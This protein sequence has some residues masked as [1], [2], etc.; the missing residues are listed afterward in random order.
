M[1]KHL[2]AI[3]ASVSALCLAA[4]FCTS[5][6]ASAALGF[7]PKTVMTKSSDMWNS[8]RNTTIHLDYCTSKDD[9]QDYLYTPGRDIRA[10]SVSSAPGHGVAIN[11][12]DVLGAY[13]GSYDFWQASQ[14]G[15]YNVEKAYDYF[16]NLGYNCGGIYVAINDCATYVPNGNGGYREISYAENNTV[17]F[18]MGS[19]NQNAH[20]A[21][22]FLGSATDI[23]THELGR[24]VA[25]RQLGLSGNSNISTETAAVLN[26]YSDIF[27]ELADEKNDWKIGASVF[28]ENG[29]SGS[30]YSYRDIANPSNTHN[31][32]NSN[33]TLYTSYSAWQN[34]YNANPYNDNLVIGG[35]TVLSHAAYIMSQ[36]NYFQNH[37]DQLAKIWLVSL[38]KY[39]TSNPAN[40][41]MYDCREAVLSAAADVLSQTGDPYYMSTVMLVNM[42][43]SSTGIY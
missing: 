9:Y 23:A 5:L 12:N 32:R 14:C 24:I 40:I 22:R 42:A 38:T 4:S 20:G 29:T 17:F 27:A 8:Y 16:A 18:G 43:L 1:K 2:K 11:Y 26:A 30:Y 36:M 15:L 6:T 34:A 7:W 28:V 13:T 10:V 39:N 33:L 31:P 25:E 3:A 35:S 37:K 41:T 19:S 21:V